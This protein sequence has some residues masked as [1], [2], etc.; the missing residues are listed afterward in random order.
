MDDRG[1]TATLF[2]AA[3]GVRPGLAARAAADRGPPRR[4]RHPAA[5]RSGPADGQV[6]LGRRLSRPQHGRRPAGRDQ[7]ADGH[8]EPAQADQLHRRHGSLEL[9]GHVHSG[10]GAGDGAGRGRRLGLFRGPGLAEPVVRGPGRAGPGGQADAEFHDGP[11][12]RDRGLHRLPRAPHGRAAFR[13][14]GRSRWPRSGGPAPS[15]RSPTFRTCPISPA[16]CSRSSTATV[17]AATTTTGATA[18]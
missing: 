1:E 2:T 3:Q 13:S 14:A 4:V 8:R 7:E 15:S 5:G 6:S 16:T 17:C 12:R 11:A 18:A 9:R 10:A